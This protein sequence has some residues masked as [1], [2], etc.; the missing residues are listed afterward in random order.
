MT[1]WEISLKLSDPSVGMNPWN[2]IYN[3][4]YNQNDNDVL[5][6]FKLE[7]DKHSNLFYC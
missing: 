6:D 4:N 2:Q 1:N 5:R 7:Y 3:H